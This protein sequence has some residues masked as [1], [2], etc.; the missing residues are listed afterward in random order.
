MDCPKCNVTLIVV[1]RHKIELDY[2]LECKGIWFDTDELSLLSKAID[3]IDFNAPDPA[4]FT[5]P[6]Q[7]EKIIK[8]PRCNTD[9]DKVLMKN[10]PPILD[11][12][13]NN[14]GIWFDNKELGQY[15]QNNTIR[16]DDSII[17]FL[18]EVL[19]S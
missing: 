2:C 16:T 9:M 12:C 8:C 6:D 19:S 3:G 10:K 18:Q 14:H 13:P 11:Y 5:I 1:E 15:V 4:F 17:Q 7:N